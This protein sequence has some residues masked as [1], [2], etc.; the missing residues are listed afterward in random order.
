MTMTAVGRG[1]GRGRGG[2]AMWEAADHTLR[3]PGE[4]SLSKEVQD[5]FSTLIE[6]IDELD[7]NSKTVPDDLL[8]LCKAGLQTSESQ[9]TI[10]WLVAKALDDQ[11][12]G[13]KLTFAVSNKSIQNLIIKI[14]ESGDQITV[15]RILMSILQIEYENRDETQKKDPVKF[16]NGVSLLGEFYYRMK[17]DSGSVISVLTK[18][19][20][21]YL[22]GL[23]TTASEED[24]LLVARMLSI[25][26]RNILAQQSSKLEELILDVKSVLIDRNLSA[27]SRSML[28]LI[29]DLHIHQYSSLPGYLQKFYV[30]HIGADTML[31]I[32]EPQAELTIVTNF[33]SLGMKNIQNDAELDTKSKPDGGGILMKVNEPETSVQYDTFDQKGYAPNFTQGKESF[34]NN[35][36]IP[37]AIRGSGAV[38]NKKHKDKRSPHNQLHK[39]KSSDDANWSKQMNSKNTSW[40]HDDRFNKEYEHDSCMSSFKSNK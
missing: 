30:E 2:W 33:R 5:E 18:P 9:T 20:L 10:E 40:G 21:N 12:F 15:R 1:R 29:L 35:A 26:G 14:N 11:L 38:A 13:R 8:Q 6:R 28:I 22:K 23:L 37:R 17:L 32:Q 25:N 16:R 39:E 19:M 3:R 31:Q 24:I 7:L 34:R 4:P 36:P 27:Y